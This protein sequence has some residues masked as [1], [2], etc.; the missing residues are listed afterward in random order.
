MSGLGLFRL[1]RSASK[2]R[3][4]ILQTGFESKDQARAEDALRARW[5]ER[6]SLLKSKLVDQ[7]AAAKLAA[8]LTRSAQ[9]NA[10]PKSLSCARFM[11]KKRLAVV[12]SIWALVHEQA[13]DPVNTVTIISG[14][15]T[16]SPESLMQLD[17]R[18]LLNGLRTDLNRCGAAKAD[19]GL[20]GFLHGEFEPNRRLYQPH[21]H[22]VA[23]GEMSDVLDQ[24][25]DLDKYQPVRGNDLDAI[26]IASPV[27]IQRRPLS[28]MPLPLTYLLKSYWPSRWVSDLRPDGSY[29]RKY[30]SARIPEPY[31]SQ[32]LLWLD[33]WGLKD[34]TLMMGMFVS[35]DGLKLRIPVLGRK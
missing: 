6:P 26:P 7:G 22:L 5:L 1:P 12:S 35:K 3:K 23:T 8:R 13:A 28:N 14:K 20:I 4:G 30:D 15:W 10:F 19:G 18:K 33:Q 32:A 21:C 16:T 29:D 17:P 31:H 27:R 34:I 2:Y 9:S 24:L 11:R 25:R